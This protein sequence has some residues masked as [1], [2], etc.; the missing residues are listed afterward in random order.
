MQHAV[1]VVVAV[2][3]RPLILAHTPTNIKLKWNETKQ[4]TNE[5]FIWFAFCV[6]ALLFLE[7]ANNNDNFWTYNCFPGSFGHFSSSRTLSLSS[8]SLSAPLSLSTHGQ[9]HNRIS[10]IFT[11][12]SVHAHNT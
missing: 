11:F 2:V 4:N 12:H 9:M 7:Y 10:R 1:V 3:A 8:L 5:N 6:C